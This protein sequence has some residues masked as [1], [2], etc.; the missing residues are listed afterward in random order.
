MIGDL[1][2]KLSGTLTPTELDALARRLD[3]IDSRMGIL[4]NWIQPGGILPRFSY[5]Y[6]E[7]AE[8]H[9]GPPLTAYVTRTSSQSINDNTSTPIEWASKSGDWANLLSWSSGVPS[10]LGINSRFVNQ[11]FLVGGYVNF[12][13]NATGFRAVDIDQFYN[14]G[15]VAATLAQ[16]PAT[17]TQSCVVPFFTLL[18][19]IDPT[20]KFR[21][22]VRQISGGAL[23]VDRAEASIL[24]I[25]RS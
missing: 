19:V 23:N 16:L 12:A 10:E 11:G 22:N 2:R 13:A 6:S 1:V 25:Q 4:Q 7:L 8:F 3:D 14:G 15:W 18:R 9:Y 21:L 17:A 20:T 24:Y 5:M